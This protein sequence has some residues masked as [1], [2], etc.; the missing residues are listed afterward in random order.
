MRPRNQCNRREQDIQLVVSDPKACNNIIVKNQAIFEATEVFL[1][2]VLFSLR[3]ENWRWPLIQ[4]ARLG[5]C[6]GQCSF[7]CR[8]VALFETPHSTRQ[9]IVSLI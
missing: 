9:L 6:L 7:L 3:S 2:Y 5:R 4:E 1:L 8:V